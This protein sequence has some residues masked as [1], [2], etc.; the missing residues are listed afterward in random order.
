MVV[1]RTVV[2]AS[3]TEQGGIYVWTI[4]QRLSPS[5]L[6]TLPVLEVAAHSMVET[7]VKERWMKVLEACPGC[8]WRDGVNAYSARPTGTEFLLA[9]IVRAQT[10]EPRL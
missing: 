1:L 7:S 4:A 10:L 8:V 3:V 2:K 6:S 9:E 5:T